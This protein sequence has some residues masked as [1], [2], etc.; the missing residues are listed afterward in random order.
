MSSQ[1][2]PQAIDINVATTKSMGRRRRIRYNRILQSEAQKRNL[3]FADISERLIDAKTGVIS[4]EYRHADPLNHHLDPER[5]APL[6]A[7]ALN[8]LIL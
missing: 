7:E 5:A 1:D 2:L 4:D 8:K 3:P 6:W